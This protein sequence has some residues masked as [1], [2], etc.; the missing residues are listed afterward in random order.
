MGK[1]AYP[2]REQLDTANMR[3]RR[4]LARLH[5]E[6]GRHDP[7]LMPKLA[8]IVQNA[9]TQLAALAVE[10]EK[11]EDSSTRHRAALKKEEDKVRATLRKGVRRGDPRAVSMLERL[12]ARRPQSGSDGDDAA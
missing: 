8:A 12:D 3:F 5:R 10:A 2:G 4:A 9:T 1:P 7:A 6:A 11:A